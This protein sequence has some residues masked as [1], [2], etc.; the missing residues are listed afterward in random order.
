MGDGGISNTHNVGKGLSDLGT[1]GSDYAPGVFQKYQVIIT[2]ASTIA[3]TLAT[4]VWGGF[5]GIEG[6]L[7]ALETKM[8][9]ISDDII[10]MKSDIRGL[11]EKIDA[12]HIAIARM[13]QD[14]AQSDEPQATQQAVDS[15]AHPSSDSVSYGD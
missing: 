14:I 12:I 6:R 13:G 2:L 15:Q 5:F 4:L 11:D 1:K 7:V 3:F 8:E 10:E 9:N